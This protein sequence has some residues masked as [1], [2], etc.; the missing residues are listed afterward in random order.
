MSGT[1]KTIK[2]KDDNNIE[3]N[4]FPKTVL[5][6]VVKPETNETLDVILDELNNKIDNIETGGGGGEIPDDV[7][8]QLDGKVSKSG[9]AMTGA[10]DIST[11]SFPALTLTRSNAASGAA[12]KFINSNGT[13]GSIGMTENGNALRRWTSDGST[14]YEVL[15]A[16]NYSSYALPLTGGT[17][18]GATT[19][20]DG[21]TSSSES[22]YLRQDYMVWAMASGSGSSGYW[23]F[24]T[25]KTNNTYIGGQLRMTV[26]QR[27]LY[28]DIIIGFNGASTEAGADISYIKQTGNI[29]Q[30]YYV[31]TATQTFDLYLTKSQQYDQA[32]ITRVDTSQYIK[33]RTAITWVDT[34]VTSLPSG[35]VTATKTNDWT[36]FVT[37]SSGTISF[38]MNPGSSYLISV[39]ETATGTMHSM[40]II[41]ASRNTWTYTSLENGGSAFTSISNT[42]F[43]FNFGSTGSI[44]NNPC[45]LKYIELR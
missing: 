12:I 35:Y 18:T 38:T 5:E 15:D 25:I 24:A 2:A 3:Q 1:I 14:H 26:H 32:T 21:F 29:S 22:T 42:T 9:D 30:V 23:K 43:T 45:I 40:G 27:G 31:K 6:A 34:H 8:E 20:S 19:F 7:Q 4:I 44:T 39:Y 37:S 13:L 16:E 33:T 41:N 10:L 36:N 28:G 17:V 11:T